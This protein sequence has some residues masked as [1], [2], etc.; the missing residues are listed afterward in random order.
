MKNGFIY[1]FFD[2][3]IKG[4]YYLNLVEFFKYLARVYAKR[5][6]ESISKEILIR[7][8]NIAIDIYQIFKWGVL[9]FF[10]VN[11][12][13][14]VISLMIICYLLGGNLFTYF[15]Y[16]VWGSKYFQGVNRATLNRRFLNSIIAIA[17]YLFCYAYLYQFHY[18]EG[19]SWP[20]GL[21]DTV[22]AW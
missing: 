10:W 7:N 17:Y 8:S 13:D 14:G 12:Y 20:D 18:Y 6:R 15:Y 2:S 3:V 21:V 19:I 9:I 22:N 11:G 16:H 4:L 1:P 5:K